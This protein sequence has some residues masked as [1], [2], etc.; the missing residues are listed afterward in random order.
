MQIFGP[1]LFTVAVG[2][3]GSAGWLFVAAIFLLA[4]SLLPVLVRRALPDR[5]ANP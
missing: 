2:R 1:A 4:A 3:Y 5:P